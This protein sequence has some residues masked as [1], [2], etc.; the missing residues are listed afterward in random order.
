MVDSTLMY[1]LTPNK[2]SRQEQVRNNAKKYYAKRIEENQEFY[3]KEKIRIREY[4]KNKYREDP[5]YAE[6]VKAKRREYYKRMKE[7]QMSAQI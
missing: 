5:E 1:E 6:K 7:I 2:L 3:Q 4:N